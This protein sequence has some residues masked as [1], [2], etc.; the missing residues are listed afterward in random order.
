MT[1]F[2]ELM[3]VIHTERFLLWQPAKNTGKY[4]C[5]GWAQKDFPR[6]IGDLGDA[7]V[8]RVNFYGECPEI[9]LD[10]SFKQTRKE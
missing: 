6:L 10:E 8:K 1:T 2:R 3:S 9:F 5:N 4:I 7:E